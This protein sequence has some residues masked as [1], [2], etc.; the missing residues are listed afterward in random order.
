MATPFGDIFISIVFLTTDY[1]SVRYEPDPPPRARHTYNI[2]IKHVHTHTH[3]HTRQCC[4]V[5]G[6][7]KI[8]ILHLYHNIIILH[9]CVWERL[10][11]NGSAAAA[12]YTTSYH[13]RWRQ[14]HDRRRRLWPRTASGDGAC[15]RADIGSLCFP[16][17]STWTSA[18]LSLALLRAHAYTYTARQSRLRRVRRFARVRV[19]T[20]ES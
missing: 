3:A 1:R 9:N 15:V 8:R 16:L 12:V 5:L 7:Y 13:N 6:Y 20:A 14:E 19:H 17:R 11:K 2:I 4:P 18:A 10:K